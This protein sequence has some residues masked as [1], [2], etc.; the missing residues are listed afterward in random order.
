MT[1]RFITKTEVEHADFP[2]CHVEWMSNA[3]LTG[4]QQLLLVRA[5]FPPGEQHNFHLHPAREEIIYVLEGTA[6]QWVG[7]E[8]RLLGPG[9]MAHIPAGLAHA[10]KNVGSVPLKF[11]AILAPSDAE[12]DFTVDVFDEAPWCSLLPPIAY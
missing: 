12:G 1:N 8:K 2:W 4:A 7:Q 6:E 10:T 5:E 11:L 3:A 9:E